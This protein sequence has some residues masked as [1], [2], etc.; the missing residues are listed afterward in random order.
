MP[1]H[2]SSAEAEIRDAAVARIRQRRP[3]AR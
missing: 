2:R 1:A 3:D